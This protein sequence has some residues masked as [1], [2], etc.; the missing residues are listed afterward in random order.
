MQLT[1]RSHVA[2]RKVLRKAPGGTE[3][4]PAVPQEKYPSTSSPFQHLSWENLK[5]AM[6]DGK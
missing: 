1:W 4:K 5:L 2:E 6:A 3:I